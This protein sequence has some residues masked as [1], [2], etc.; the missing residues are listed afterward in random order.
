[1]KPTKIIASRGRSATA[2]C[3]RVI[4]ASNHFGVQYCGEPLVLFITASPMPQY[5]QLVVMRCPEHIYRG[6]GVLSEERFYI[7]ERG[8]YHVW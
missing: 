7:D 6:D 2:T 3:E 4:A 8:D 1:M 5:E